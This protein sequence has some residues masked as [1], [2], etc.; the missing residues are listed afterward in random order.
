[1]YLSGGFLLSV[2]D[3]GITV[4]G[5]GSVPKWGGQMATRREEKLG[6]LFFM[7]ETGEVE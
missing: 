7:R 5:Y 1:V 2:G 4:D 6:F 3:G